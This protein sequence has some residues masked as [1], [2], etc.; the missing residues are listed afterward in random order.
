MDATIVSLMGSS[1][2]YGARLMSGR[3]EAVSAAVL[4]L[5]AEAR[6]VEGL[7]MESLGERAGL[8]RTYVGLLERGK[9]KPTL[10]VAA[11]LADALGLR[12]GDLVLRAEGI[13][14]ADEDGAPPGPRTAAARRA[15]RECVESDKTLREVTS[16]TAEAILLAVDDAY[17]TLD[18]LDRELAKNDSPPLARL[19]ELANLSAMLGNILGAGIARHSKGLYERS[20]PHKYQ[21]LRSTSDGEHIEIKMALESHKPKGHLSKAGHYLTFR[22]V[23]GYRDEPYDRKTRGVVAYVWEVRF[24]YVRQQDFSES[25]TKG[26]SGKTAVIKTEILKKMERLYFDAAYFPMARLDGE[27][28]RKGLF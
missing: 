19:V 24:G 1:S 2:S 14:Q 20:G 15:S 4:V 27:W 16:L 26:D 7:S 11:S 13:A 10:A 17:F 6:K 18:L 3:S 28:G 21:D 12:L 22:Y 25:D 5:L 23:L 8:D 9:R